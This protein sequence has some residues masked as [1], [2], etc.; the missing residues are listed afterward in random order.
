M[1]WLIAW[2]KLDWKFKLLDTH[3]FKIYT[4]SEMSSQFEKKKKQFKNKILN[5]HNRNNLQME[6]SFEAKNNFEK[7]NNKTMISTYNSGNW[8]VENIL[9]IRLRY[10]GLKRMRLL[11][12]LHC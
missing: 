3:W 12:W 4:D 1:D 6:E 2:L 8:K 10:V 11:D 5:H 7:L 9:K